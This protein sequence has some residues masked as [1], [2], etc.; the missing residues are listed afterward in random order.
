MKIISSTEDP[1]II[2]DILMFSRAAADLKAKDI[3]K[4]VK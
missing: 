4:I 1:L 3:F 2:R